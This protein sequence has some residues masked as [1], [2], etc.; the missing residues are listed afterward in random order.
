MLGS[1]LGAVAG[2]TG[3]LER[4]RSTCTYSQMYPS[5]Q[6]A[7]LS[8]DLLSKTDSFRLTLGDEEASC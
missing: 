1:I 8:Y 6:D 7:K 3:L 2:A 4:L 5:F